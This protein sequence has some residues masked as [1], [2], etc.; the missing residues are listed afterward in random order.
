MWMLLLVL[1]GVS[2]RVCTAQVTSMSFMECIILD[3][4]PVAKGDAHF[5][6]NIC[7]LCPTAPNPPTNLVVVQVTDTSVIVS[8][9]PPT[10]TTDVS[11]Y[12]I[13][14]DDGT[15]EEFVDVFGSEASTVTINGLT[16]GS[17]YSITIVST[18]EGLPSEVVGPVVIELL[19][20]KYSFSTDNLCT[21]NNGLD[22]M[23][24]WILQ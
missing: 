8:W 24:F 6:V 2:T 20:M 4:L 7:T 1:L 23:H 17:T 11:G 19:G 10:D 3:Y 13:F 5:T 22:F 14:Y 21:C 18:S 15:R 9:T 16:T 12:R